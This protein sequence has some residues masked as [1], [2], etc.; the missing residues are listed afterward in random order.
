M[1]QNVKTFSCGLSIVLL[2][3]A[4]SSL[5]SSQTRTTAPPP[6]A[7][8]T[9]TD[10][11]GVVPAG[12]EVSIRANEQIS[13]SEAG[14]TFDAETA[15]DV[16][17]RAGEVIVPKGSQ[18]ELVVTEVDE[19]GAVGTKTMQLALRSLTVRGRRYDVSTASQEQRGDEGLGAN[20]RTAETVG[21]GAVLGAVLGAIIGGGRGAATGAVIG[22][23][24]GATAQVLTRGDEV[25][26]PA[27]TILTFRLNYPI[28]L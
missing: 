27:E 2:A 4:C 9:A 3:A 10:E 14:R 11:N 24:G 1:R 23:A 17:T 18:A 7:I 28:E 15:Q 13:T 12:T 5:R 16:T 21:G 26:V 20:R 22:G 8:Q 19:G 25:R 6:G